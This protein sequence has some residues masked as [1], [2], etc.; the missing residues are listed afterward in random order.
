MSRLTIIIPYFQ[1]TSTTAFEETLASVLLHKTPDAEVCI[2]NGVGYADPWNTG[3]EGVRFIT[4]ERSVR[5]VE[6]L[7]EAVRRSEGDI[8]HLLYP[9]T[10][11][12]ADW[13]RSVLRLF[14]VP[15]TGIVIPCVCD[16]RK[17][18]RIFSLGIRYGCGGTLRTIRRS[19]WSDDEH[20][21]IVPHIS[22]VFFRRSF[23]QRIGLFDS[24]FLPQISYIDAALAIMS[25][26]GETVVDQSSRIAVSPN[27]LPT[28]LP[29]TW[30]LQI[31]RLY[32][33]WSNRSL[34]M[35][36]FL[37]HLRS[38]LVDFWRHLPRLKAFQLLAGRCLGLVYFGVAPSLSCCK[39]G[40]K[41][42]LKPILPFG[43]RKDPASKKSA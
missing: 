23:L 10:E 5:P 1:G 26:Q 15:E 36:G 16:R 30:G 39:R 17:P 41:K 11:V 24:A 9:G 31:E 18:K 29:F 8:I 20:Q 32:F 40:D 43:E 27:L 42:G 34:F 14:D 21:T 25:L 4:S 7:N 13:T 3:S 33:R 19:Q 28:M 22:A 38:N 12:S 35:N 6:L 2:A 37:E